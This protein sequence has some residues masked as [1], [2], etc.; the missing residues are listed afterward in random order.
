MPASAGMTGD[1]AGRGPLLRSLHTIAKA[2]D[3]YSNHV[4]GKMPASAGMTGD[5]AGMTGDR[6]GMTID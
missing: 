4:L 6:T 5:R 1:C 2:L 3:Q